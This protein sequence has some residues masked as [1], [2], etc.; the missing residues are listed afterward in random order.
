MPVTTSWGQCLYDYVHP[1]GH[2]LNWHSS[3]CWGQRRQ[4]LLHCSIYLHLGVS[5]VDWELTSYNVLVLQAFLPFL[6][7]FSNVPQNKIY[8]WLWSREFI[9]VLVLVLL[10][11]GCETG[12]S[13]AALTRQVLPIWP[14]V[15]S[16]L[17]Q[18]SCLSLPSTTM[19][20]ISHYAQLLQFK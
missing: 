19:T 4:S 17:Q 6:Y 8:W 9:F 16:D 3:H 5:C 20:D 7:A 13:Y 18:S 11:M 14:R 15:S 1:V 12:C 2:G 10:L